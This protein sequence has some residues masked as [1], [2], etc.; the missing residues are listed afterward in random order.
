MSHTTKLVL[1]IAVAVI[2]LGGG[3]A[4]WQNTKEVGTPTSMEE[5]T[6]LPSGTDTTDQALDSDMTAVDAQLKAVGTDNANVTT[7]ISE[8]QSQ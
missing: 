3:Y 4:Y 6:S 7:S 2:V 8:V 1:G 5:V